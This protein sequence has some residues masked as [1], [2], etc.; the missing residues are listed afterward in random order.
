MSRLKS[1]SELPTHD[2][3]QPRAPAAPVDM[4]SLS[5]NQRLVLENKK[6]AL[7]KTRRRNTIEVERMLT[8]EPV[9]VG[10]QIWVP[11]SET[12]WRVVQVT[13]V[14]GEERGMILTVVGHRGEEKVDMRDIGDIYRVNPRVV[15]DMTSLYYIHEAGI[16]ENLNIRSRLDNQRPYTFMAN[17]LIAVNPLRKVV[18]PNIKD[19]VKTQMGDRP[20]H[21]YAVA[22]V[23]FQQ[24][25][26]RSPSQDQ[27]IVI[28]GESG[29]GKTETSKIV[30]RY[31]TTREHIINGSKENSVVTMA[32]ISSQELDRRLW[33]TNP[34]LEAFGNAKTLRNHNSS[35]FGKFMKLQ[36]QDMGKTG[37]H[38]VG[39]YIET[40][41]LEKF[42]V[43]AQ[44]PNERN[45]HIFYYL[46]AGASDELSNQLQLSAPTSYL[47]LNQS[48]CVSDP[49]IDDELLFDDV[50]SALKSVGVD[51][52]MQL[53]VWTVLSGLLHFGNVVLKNRETSEGDAGD[54][55]K[56]TAG[57]LR[58]AAKHL[59]VDVA[60]LERVITTR[61]INTRGENFVIKRNAKEGMYVR[62]A[63][64]K[65]I[66]QHL[67][68]WIVNHINV[69]L[70]HGPPDLSFI[71]V[72][73][74]FGFESFD[75]NDFEQLLINYAN[76]AL[77]ATFNQQVFIAEQ[78]LFTQEGIDVGKIA[79]P[80]NRDC[81]ELI[82]SKPNGVLP[83]LDSESRTQ[84]PSDE[85]WNTTLHKTHVGH[86][87][88]LAPH[89]KDK[90][91][92]FIIKHFATMVTYTVGNF[93]DKNND[94][95]PKDLEDLV[96]SSTSVLMA[97]IYKSGVDDVGVAAFKKPSVSLKFC[98][99]MQSLVDTLNA[100]RCNFIR[101]VKP[102]PTMTLG[103]FDNGYV[104]DQLRCTGMLATCE[105]LKVG[106]PTRV[107]Y[108]EICRI[109]K[110]VLPPNVTPMFQCYNDR[111][112]TEAV[113]WAFRVDPDAYRLGR[114]RV[115]FK[116][117]K[118]AL[119]DAL[120]KV[121]MK[122][123]GPWIVARL[124][125]WLARRRWRY[126]TAKV[127]AQRAFLWLLDYVRHRKAAIIKLQSVVRM[128]NVRKQFL[129]A[130]AYKREEAKRKEVAIHRWKKAIAVVRGRN[131]L[132]SLFI[133]SRTKLQAEL[134]RINRAATVLQTIARGKL[135]RREAEKLRRAAQE[136]ALRLR[137]KKEADA[138]LE[139]S[140]K[141]AKR[142]WHA[143]FIAV[144]AQRLFVSR[145]VKIHN[146]RLVAEKAEQRA[147]E[148]E[149]LRLQRLDAE[150]IRQQQLQ[151]QSA[152]KIQAAYR[153][154]VGRDE[155]SRVAAVAYAQSAALAASLAAEE[156]ARAA[157]LASKAHEAE[158]AA[159]RKL[160]SLEASRM[161][162]IGAVP[163]S[164]GVL[165]TAGVAHGVAGEAGAMGAL[166]SQGVAGALIDKQES[167][168]EPDMSWMPK[169]TPAF[170]EG[171]TGNG[172]TAD[173]L[174][175]AGVDLF[176]EEG[177]QIQ[178]PLISADDDDLRNPVER[179]QEF[180]TGPPIPY[181]GGIFTCTLLGH[182]KLQDENWGDEYTEYVLRV[183]WGR[184]ILEQSKTAWLVGG[185]YNDFNALHQ[186]LKAAASG[187]KGKR[188]PWFPRFPKRHPFSSLI[189]KNQEEKFIT[190]R[191]KELN[192]YMTQVLT[193]MPDALLNVHM[194]RFL[195]L[196]LRTNDICEREAF[197]EARK[198]W[199]EEEREALAH[200]ADAEPLND[201]EIH[202][203]EELVHSLL[204]KIIYA[205]GDIRT[206]GALQEMIHAVKVL[207]PR[208]AASAQIGAGVNMELVPLAMQLQD[209]I[210]DAFNQY[211]DTLLALR[212]GQEFD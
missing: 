35:R 140:K 172:L 144:T 134:A 113:L 151:H 176:G 171:T 190:K 154:K 104:V 164:I 192:R 76:E 152:V 108:E 203:V 7:D 127:M 124:K 208:V 72:L 43:V 147:R 71:G 93:I 137:L 142:R 116:T 95:I 56:E 33:D 146:S 143:A 187:Q 117:G 60:Y 158:A 13:K 84:K 10:S 99:Q 121:D 166:G 145:F 90:K 153:G 70:G 100:T 28:S 14:H 75:H 74:I 34:I 189:G 15:D 4:N 19:Y 135:A 184:D 25:A 31:I 132:N 206:D 42:R 68:D 185:R 32:K 212:L 202:E 82:S 125:K 165:G 182:R 183:T 186:E 17:V 69:S 86:A 111:T 201:S 191:E 23:A 8:T 115:F 12:V 210:Q 54:I 64:V 110:P 85:K 78:E 91:F 170:S 22:E 169:D 141:T 9:E 11:D 148:E 50:C 59:G 193:Q 106:L 175:Q 63:I 44:I 55:T 87:H 129:V 160:D 49:N 139:A 174:H 204:E 198:Q 157:E 5:I 196:T 177:A 36:F 57:A 162:T 80:D 61:E 79:W 112:F 194:D 18:E 37:L 133:T 102:N 195:Q 96:L 48:G 200:A 156:A 131:A 21:P 46:L 51:A 150:R 138:R 97:Q 107:S 58:T 66:Y 119:L 47:Y 38:L 167:L 163:A 178:G 1:A 211:N 2:R 30:L 123:M 45:F 41:L 83:L 65:S 155:A 126:A 16:L 6:R 67:F 179:M 136:A 77:Q 103:T 122:K 199:E 188:A 26:L 89:E 181:K 149:I 120:L 159:L 62:D 207:Q 197:A 101:C 24:M 20:P 53:H 105:L 52:A 3:F 205:Q 109:Y 114:T 27:S 40:Y 98:D 118:I 180:P 81:I 161:A 209:D 39:A 88:F 92:V 94:T 73:D 168:V 128:Y 29:A 130:R 173:E